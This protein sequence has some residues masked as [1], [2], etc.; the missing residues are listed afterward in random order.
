MATVVPCATA[1]SSPSG[2]RAAPSAA[3]AAGSSGVDGSL[4]TVTRSS[5][6]ATKSVNVPPVSMPR[7]VRVMEVRPG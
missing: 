5:V 7:T 4:C 6:I 2:T 1:S 3:A